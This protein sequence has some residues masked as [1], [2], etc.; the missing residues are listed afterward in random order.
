MERHY[1]SSTAVVHVTF[2]DLLRHLRRQAYMTQRDLALATGYSIGQI[3]RFEQNQCVPDLST[4]T[5]RFLPTLI[6]VSDTVTR[7]RLLS[8]ADTA[9]VARQQGQ[10]HHQSTTMLAG[11]EPGVGKAPVVVLPPLPIPATPLLGREREVAQ[12]CALLQRATV[13]LLTLTG[14]PGVG[15]TRLGLQGAADLHTTFPDGV[16]FVSLAAISDP[17]LILTTIAQALGVTE[18]AGQSCLVALT[19]A[20]RTKQLLLLLDNFEHLVQA[21]PLVSNLLAVAPQLKVLVTSRSVLHIRGEH[22]LVVSPL[23]LPILD[24]LPPLEQLVQSPSV[25]LFIARAQAV[26]AGFPVTSTT[27]ATIAR[28][29]TRLD[30]L[31]L[32]IELAAARVKLFPPQAL[33]TRLERRLNLLTTGACDLPKHQQTL[34][35][36]IDWSYQLLDA[37]HQR[38]LSHLGVFVGGCTPEAVE[39]VCAAEGTLGMDVLNGLA[40]LVDHS[41]VQRGEGLDGEPRFTMLETIREYALE[42]L[43]ESGEGEELQQRHAD[44]YLA[45]VETIAPL[46][47]DAQQGGWLDRLEVEHDNL[48]TTLQWAIDRGDGATAGRMSAALARFWYVHSYLSEGRTWLEQA[49]ALLDTGTPM[50]A[51]RTKVLNGAGILAYTQG[52]YQPA[53]ARLQESIALAREIGDQPSTALAL[54]AMGWTALVQGDHAC[55]RSFFEEGLA[56]VQELGQT[57]DIAVGFTSLGAM[58]LVQGDYSRAHA[59]CEKSLALGRTLGAKTVIGVSLATLGSMALIQGDNVRAQACFE[60]CLPLCQQTGNK[61]LTAVCLIGLAGAAAGQRQATRAARLAGAS[62]SLLYAIGSSIPPVVRPHYDMIVAA[63]RFQLGEVAFATLWASGRAL[64]PE[65]AIAYA[66]NEDA[67]DS[68]LSLLKTG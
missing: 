36:T 61:L 32:A 12:V 3:C 67:K 55:A 18:G 64:S 60:E 16:V 46:L 15:K 59:L 44:Y 7:E 13:R 9:R 10:H 63:M 57:H 28:I 53:F 65:Q 37:D 54:D 49:L 47:I 38:L 51:V 23:A 66:L 30:G 24:P 41:L 4:L 35:N 14:A 68:C 11:L 22:E 52:D 43:A 2:G 27:V 56:L 45:L 34:R 26:H 29:C 58:A 42:R 20:L 6:E 48:R 62:E 5:A 40:A 17:A 31:P 8:L 39:A 19:A 21:A 1:P 50:A 33:L 25:Q